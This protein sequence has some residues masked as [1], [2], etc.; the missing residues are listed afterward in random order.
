[1]IP[2]TEI[3][4]VSTQIVISWGA[5]RI[6]A[7]LVRTDRRV[8]KIDVEPGGRVTV[9]APRDAAQAEVVARCQRKSGWIFR[10]LD[11]AAGEPAFT[12]ERC[13]VSG[14][15]HLFFGRP[16]RLEI[17]RSAEHFART[18]GP[19]ILIGVREP[20]NAAQCR[21]VL[22]AFYSLEARA[23]FATRLSAV[24]P[25]F[26]RRGLRRPRLIIR[27]P[28]KRWGSFTSKG[29]VML[30]IDLVRAGPDLIDYVI[31]HELAHGFYG[32]H[33]EEWRALLESVMPDWQQ[34]KKRLENLLR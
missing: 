5:R 4:A 14:E 30:N 26:E 13:Y 18:D 23:L 9:L 32:N 27:R 19:R 2:G 34:R 20:N 17:V 1:M 25:P 28:T 16:Y 7:K 31:C 6:E 12:P 11:K 24:F 8:L 29:N 22:A 33:D 21:R 10:Q 15:T 3:S